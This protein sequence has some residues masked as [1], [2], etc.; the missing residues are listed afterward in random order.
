M[1]PGLPLKKS[2]PMPIV[3]RAVSFFSS[4]W[5]FEKRVALS[6]TVELDPIYLSLHNERVATICLPASLPPSPFHRFY[7]VQKC[8][9]SISA[10]APSLVLLSSSSSYPSFLPS[11]L[12][13]LLIY[14]CIFCLA[15]FFRHLIVLVVGRRELRRGCGGGAGET[16]LSPSPLPLP[17]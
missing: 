4:S 3:C 13:F 8:P 6:R 12:S 5:V 16:H 2:T 7:H 17:L 9:E 1:R 14:V 15:L 11:F 10:A